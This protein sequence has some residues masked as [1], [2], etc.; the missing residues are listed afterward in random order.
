MMTV[1]SFMHKSDENDVQDDIVSDTKWNQPNLH[2]KAE[3]M[4]L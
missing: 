2:R 3:E 4:T 1:G